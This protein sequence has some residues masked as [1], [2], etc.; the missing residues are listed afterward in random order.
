V[1]TDEIS[2]SSSS[3]SPRSPTG[4]PGEL[5]LPLNLLRLVN[6]PFLLYTNEGPRDQNRAMSLN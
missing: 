2:C 6:H 5:A 3:T 4:D 1:L